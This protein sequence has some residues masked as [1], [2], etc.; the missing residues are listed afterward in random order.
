MGRLRL[1]YQRSVGVEIARVQTRLVRVVLHWYL[2]QLPLFGISADVR[3]L[4]KAVQTT[5][6]KL[7]RHLLDKSYWFAAH[8]DMRDLIFWSYVRPDIEADPR[9][10]DEIMA[11]VTTRECWRT[12]MG[13][14]TL[15]RWILSNQIKGGCFAFKDNVLYF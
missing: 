10:L 4:L 7:V 15:M 3:S 1:V 8:N 6:H 2:S 12:N 5:D 13:I 14:V 11:K 9:V